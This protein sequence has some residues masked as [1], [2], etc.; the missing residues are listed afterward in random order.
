MNKHVLF[1]ILYLGIVGGLA[2]Y[3]DNPDS[4]IRTIRTHGG[5]FPPTSHYHS[6]GDDRRE[7]EDVRGG[8]GGVVVFA[9]SK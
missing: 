8:K 7:F 3:S 2:A 9:P 5:V 4:P 1:S 6:N